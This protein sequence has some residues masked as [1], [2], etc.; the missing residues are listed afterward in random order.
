LPEGNS[1]FRDVAAWFRALFSGALSAVFSVLSF[2][3]TVLT[4]LPLF[5]GKSIPHVRPLAFVI[6]IASFAFVNF[7][8]FQSKRRQIENLEGDLIVQENRIKTLGAELETQRAGGSRLTIRALPGSRYILRPTKPSPHADFDGGY[9]E[10]H[11]MIE[12]SGSSNAVVNAFTVEILELK[13]K[14]RN[15]SPEEGQKR[16]QGRHCQFGLNSALELNKKK[17]LQVEAESS[18]GEGTLSFFIS[19]LDLEMFSAAGLRMQ[20]QERRFVSLHCQLT[21]TD[22][23]G[24]TATAAFE[25]PEA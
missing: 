20:G 7:R 8:I 15:L 5:S 18:T 21:L 17:V 9:F 14:F 25:L 22:Y 1:G 23:S 19:D 6:A 4:F 16:A 24:L 3:S 12:N 13:R 11:L 2:A 10:F